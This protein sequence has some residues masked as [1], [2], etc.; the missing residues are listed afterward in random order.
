MKG[1]RIKTVATATGV[2]PELLRAWERRYEVVS[3]TRSTGGY[4]EYSESDVLKLRLLRD[5][6]SRGFAISEVASMGV[7]DLERLAEGGHVAGADAPTLPAA[8][9]APSEPL[10]ERAVDGDSAGLRE[11]LRR[12]LTVMP[13]GEALEAVILPLLR[14]VAWRAERDG[15]G[16]AR[17]LVAEE[18]RGFVGPLAP[19]E[20]APRVLVATSTTQPAPVL[21]VE[22][23]AH[24]LAAGAAPFLTTAGV[25]ALV[26]R[27]EAL[28]AAAV[29][30]CLDGQAAMPELRR[31]PIALPLILVGAAGPVPAGVRTARASFDLPNALTAVLDPEE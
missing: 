3:P 15:D 18:I 10:V 17:E 25:G 31:W 22:A 4:R 11:G 19:P 20:P 8:T 1:Y 6:T 14:E 23:A 2:S 29:L 12:A 13:T 26:D 27:G 30:L 7:A 5:L 21:Q 28:G 16:R 9:P 24:V